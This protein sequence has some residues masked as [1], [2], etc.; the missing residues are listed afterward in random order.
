MMERQFLLKGLK[1]EASIGFY[2]AERQAKQTIVI[3]AELWLD[4]ATEPR[5][6]SVGSTLDYDL[7]RDRI[8]EIATAR[9]YDLQE[10]LA[11]ALFDALAGLDH[12]RHVR[13]RTAKPDA[14]ADCDFIAYQLAGASQP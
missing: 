12:V 10:T 11:R 6:D 14:Y 3:D 13:I 9:H 7:V 4:P 2:E 8:L 1:T 5:D